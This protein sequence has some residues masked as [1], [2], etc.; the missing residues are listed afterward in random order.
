MISREMKAPDKM[1]RNLKT[2]IK[3]TIEV[4][5][6]FGKNRCHIFTET[7]LKKVLRVKKRRKTRIPT[8]SLGVASANPLYHL[9]R[10]LIIVS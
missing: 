2:L 1:M 8:A 6:L 4:F 10:T 9:F 5:L 3:V 7:L